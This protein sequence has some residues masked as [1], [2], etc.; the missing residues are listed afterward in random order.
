MRVLS[1]PINQMLAHYSAVVVGSGYGGAIAA[2]RIA[3]AGRDVCVLERGKELHPGEYPNS[4]LSAF[5][6]MQVHTPTAD[7]GSAV[8]MFDFHVGRDITA[9]VGC[10]LGGT[11]LINANVA[12]EPGDTIFSDDRWPV[13]LRGQPEVLRPFM[14]AAREMLGSNPYPR[15]WTDLPKLHALQ[16]AAASLGREV[17]RPDINV[18]F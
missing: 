12:L 8:G 9:L 6:E 17:R 13:A 3:R 15:T 4:A 11:S 7:H 14:Q 5:R 16:R 1:R 10:G 2:D 18:T